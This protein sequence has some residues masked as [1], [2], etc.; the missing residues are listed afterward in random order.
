MLELAKSTPSPFRLEDQHAKRAA[1]AD[2]FTRKVMEGDL[3]GDPNKKPSLSSPPLW[4]AGTKSHN[5][6][7]ED[8]DSEEEEFQRF[9]ASPAKKSNR[10]PN[11]AKTLFPSPMRTQSD[12]A[13]VFASFASDLCAQGCRSSSLGNE[14]ISHRLGEGVPGPPELVRRGSSEVYAT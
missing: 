2:P 12:S 4:F 8:D 13:V 11:T 3:G 7:L 1:V 5:N 6:L 9:F 10:P 14:D